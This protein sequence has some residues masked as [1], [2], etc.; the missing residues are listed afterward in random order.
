MICTIIYGTS[1]H[2]CKVNPT[3]NLQKPLLNY[4]NRKS[5][6]G[7]D[8]LSI[9][10]DEYRP[11][12]RVRFTEGPSQNYYEH[13]EKNKNTEIAE[14]KQFQQRADNSVYQPIMLELL[15]LFGLAIHTSLERTLGKYLKATD[16][17]FRNDLRSDW[18]LSKVGKLLCTN[19]ASERPFG[20]AKAYMNIYQSLSLRT[21]ATFSLAM[22]T[23]SHRPADSRGKQ[24]RTQG[25]ERRQCGTALLATSDLQNAITKLCSVRKVNVGK[26]TAKL[27]EVFVT[28]LARQDTRR[29]QK[30]KDEEEAEKRKMQKK[31]VK[32]NK[33]MEEPLAPTIGD[34]LAHMK[35]MANAVGVCKDYLKRQVNA[36]LMRADIDEFKYPSIGDEY[37]AK[38]KKRKIKLTPSNARNEVEYLTALITL[39]MKAD[40]RRRA[41]DD[42]PVQL[43]GTEQ[44]YPQ[45]HPYPQ[46]LRLPI[47]SP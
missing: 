30:R 6:S 9:L 3:L 27:D 5:Y 18:E 37:R 40:A 25:K 26:V 2:Y 38:N 41:I 10:D 15:Q 21:L 35:S 11:W 47:P 39:M 23:G 42:A 16:G 1:G 29:Q 4:P 34:L 32:F 22:C 24:S 46:S 19:N 43:S 14:L 36:R 28:N 31:G 33:N 8:A 45:P 7:E 44:T 12:P 20:V 17:V 13:L